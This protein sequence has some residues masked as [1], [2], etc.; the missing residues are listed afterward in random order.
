MS[1]G[2]WL[3]RRLFPPLLLLTVAL[4]DGW[5]LPY[6]RDRWRRRARRQDVQPR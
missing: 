5:L 2:E 3:F 6:L 1:T 4:V